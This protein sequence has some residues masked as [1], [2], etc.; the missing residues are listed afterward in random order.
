MALCFLEVQLI[1]V[2]IGPNT[3]SAILY[4]IFRKPLVSKNWISKNWVSKNWAFLAG[5]SRNGVPDEWAFQ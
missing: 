1:F 2:P 3:N 4:C 5:R